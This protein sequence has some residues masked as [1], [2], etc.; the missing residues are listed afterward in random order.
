MVKAFELITELE[1]S[2]STS[3][4]YNVFNLLSWFIKDSNEKIIIQKQKEKIIQLEEEIIL[5]QKII[6]DKNKKY[7]IM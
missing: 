5:L 3:N 4:L 1:L 6:K 7:I 2:Y